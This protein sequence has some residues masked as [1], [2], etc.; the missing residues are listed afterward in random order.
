MGLHEMAFNSSFDLSIAEAAIKRLRTWFN[1]RNGGYVDLQHYGFGQGPASG[2][3]SSLPDDLPSE[4]ELVRQMRLLVQRLQQAGAQLPFR[5]R[6]QD[7]R[8]TVLAK[9]VFTKPQ[10]YEGKQR[11]KVMKRTISK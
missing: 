5:K 11:E 10:F 3:H 1:S 7:A 6:W 4:D 8:D 9:D 2:S